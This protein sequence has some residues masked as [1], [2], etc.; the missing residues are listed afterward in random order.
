MGPRRLHVGQRVYFN[1]GSAS[2]PSTLCVLRGTSRL[3]CSQSPTGQWSLT[4]RPGRDQYYTLRIDG[5]VWSRLIYRH[6]T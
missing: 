2:A 6:V 3:H 1:L 5:T 4:V